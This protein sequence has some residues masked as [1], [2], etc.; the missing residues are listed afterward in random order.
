M[1]KKAETLPD[2]WSIYRAINFKRKEFEDAKTGQKMTY[3]FI[4][5]DKVKGSIFMQVFSGI[6]WMSFPLLVILLSGFYF[7]MTPF[8]FLIGALTIVAYHFAAMY[9]V[10]RGPHIEITQVKKQGI[11]KKIMKK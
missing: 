3:D 2:Y 5:H 1:A 4:G 10:I 8:S 6:M 7:L 9:Y 11:M